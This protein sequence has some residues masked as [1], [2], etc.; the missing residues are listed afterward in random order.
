MAIQVHIKRKV[1]D[2]QAPELA[3]L[4]KKMRALTLDRKG[5]ISGRTFTGVVHPGV[6][7]VIGTWQSV[8]D[9]REWARC[10]ERIDLQKKID[11]LLGQPTE[12]EIFQ[13][14]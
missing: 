1:T 6:S 4:L 3:A 2:K 5:Y 10:K 8:D 11:E 14:L 13:S 12:Y 7:L 9:W